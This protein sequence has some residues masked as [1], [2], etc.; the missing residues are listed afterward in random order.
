MNSNELKTFL[1]K[2]S[3]KEGYPVQKVKKIEYKM[4]YGQV[5]VVVSFS[6]N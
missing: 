2:I 4:N 3:Q 6:L 5:S 1:E